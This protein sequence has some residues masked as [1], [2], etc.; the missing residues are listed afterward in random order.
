[1]YH[2]N[3]MQTVF[4]AQAKRRDLLREVEADRMAARARSRRHIEHIV[5]R[6]ILRVLRT[7]V[8]TRP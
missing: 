3:P 8:V 1:M 2:P 7:Q 6:K 5:E 4:L